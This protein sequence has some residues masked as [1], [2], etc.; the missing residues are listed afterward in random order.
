MKKIKDTIKNNWL[1]FGLAIIFAILGHSF[2]IYRFIKEGVIFTGPNDGLEQMLPIQKFLYEKFTSGN[3]FYSSDFGLGGDYYTDLAYYYSTSVIFFFNMIGI[4]ILDIIFNF[5]TSSI[6]F[7]AQNAFIISILKSAFAIFFTYKYLNYIKVKKEFAF[8]AGFLFVTSPIYFRFTLYWSFFSDIFIFLPLV[9]LGIE[10]Y[11]QEEKKLIFITGLTLALINNFYF[12]YHIVLIIVFYFLA[13]NILRSEYDL[14]SR[15]KQWINFLIMGLISLLISSFSFFYGVKGFLGNE[16]ADYKHSGK[17][18]NTFDL[19]ANIFYDNYLVVVLFLTIPA[20]LT[21]KFYKN[22][23]YKF[24]AVTTIILIIASFIEF[25]DILFN[26][27]SAPQK[28]WHYLITFFSSSLIAMYL[29][30]FKQVSL[31]NYLYSLIPVGIILGLSI[32]YIQKTPNLEWLPVVPVICI[33]GLIYLL[34]KNWKLDIVLKYIIISL[35]ILMNLSIVKMH[36]IID[37]YHSAII[38]RA[39]VNYINSSVYSSE[40]QKYIVKNTKKKL[41]PGEKIDWRVLEQDNTPM[42]QSFSGISLYSSIFDGKIIDFYY[43]KAMINIKKESISRYTGF[44][45]RSNLESLFGVKYVIRKDYQTNVPTNFKLIKNYDKYNVY[46]NTKDLPYVRFTNNIYNDK[47]LTTPLAREH[48][49]LNGFVSDSKVSN[50]KL[51]APDEL[52]NDSKIEFNNSAWIKDKVNEEL[53]VDADGGG[54][55]INLPKNKIKKAKDIYLQAYIELIN[56]ESNIII[57]VNGYQN[58]RLFKGS[59]YRTHQNNLMYNMSK[60]KNGKI[61]IS[62]PAGQYKLKIK[63]IQAEDYSMLDKASKNKTQY[64]LQ[65]KGRKINIKLKNSKDAYMIIPLIYRDGLSAKVDGKSVKIERANYLMSAI[66]VSE[67]TKNI[68]ISYLPPYFKTMLL[69]TIL[70]LILSFIYIYPKFIKERFFN[71]NEKFKK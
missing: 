70:G 54:L 4:Y 55:T 57:D 50:K 30:K 10:K 28:R 45:D 56:K 62:L 15:G 11:I 68:E 64:I 38:D 61:K 21:F 23:F 20:I 66:K 59:T 8:L 34:S 29:Q 49:M 6:V 43:N 32:K 58:D 9:L 41:K 7:W 16:R 67:N 48:A 19:N 33:F 2:Y 31:Q 27:L 47:D 44:Q 3:F 69:I 5:K 46:E 71:K 65:D 60:P 26:G 24:F 14:V 36:N 63:S 39:N 1:I 52:L 17:I 53:F 40:L 35:V 12:A 51:K 18:F 42:Y 37:N 22:Y 13:R 25:P